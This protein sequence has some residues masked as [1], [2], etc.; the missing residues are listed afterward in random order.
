MVYKDS[1]LL[2]AKKGFKS[3]ETGTLSLNDGRS[4]RFFKSVSFSI[5]TKV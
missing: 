3:L 1:K 5:K 2:N 4:F